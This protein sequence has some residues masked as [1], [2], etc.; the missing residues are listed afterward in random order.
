[1]VIVAI[2]SVDLEYVVKILDWGWSHRQYIF[3]DSDSNSMTPTLIPQPWTWRQCL[4]EWKTSW[5][6]WFILLREVTNCVSLYYLQICYFNVHGF[7]RAREH[8]TWA[9]IDCLAAY[10]VIFDIV[11]YFCT[12]SFGVGWG[13]NCSSLW[14]PVCFKMSHWPLVLDGF[15]IWLG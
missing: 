3:T 15:C 2:R 5:I 12:C 13:A 14:K 1:M 9:A 4:F 6:G 7:R 10:Y 11:L 8:C